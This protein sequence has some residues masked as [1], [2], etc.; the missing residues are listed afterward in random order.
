MPALI[1]DEGDTTANRLN[2]FS[3]HF[4]TA[5][6]ELNGMICSLLENNFHEAA[7]ISDPRAFDELELMTLKVF[8]ET[9]QFTSYPSQVLQFILCFLHE[10]IY[11]NHAITPTNPNSAK[12]MFIRKLY[13]YDLPKSFDYLVNLEHPDL[14]EYLNNPVDGNNFKF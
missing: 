13:E 6:A 2:D 1:A 5:D 7:N 8:F 4:V 12:I 14:T 9:E 10:M 3:P 11:I